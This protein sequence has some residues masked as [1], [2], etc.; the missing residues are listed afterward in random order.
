MRSLLDINVLLALLDEDHMQHELA[1]DWLVAN[2]EEGWA[3]CPL[4][5]NGFV[6]IYSQAAYPGAISARAAMD[7]LDATRIK[8]FHEFWSAD[9]SILDSVGRDRVHGPKQLTDLYL[10]AL[11]VRH[12]GRFVTFDERISL[13]PVPGTKKDSL[14]T[15]G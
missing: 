2:Q 8:P 13:T 1:R 11:A 3:S 15:L 12:G 10:L 4:T 9:V 7:L 6:R 14:V 5:E